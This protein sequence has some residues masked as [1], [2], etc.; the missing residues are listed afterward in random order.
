MR[1][2][3]NCST[4]ADCAR[5]R[6]QLCRDKGCLREGRQLPGSGTAPLRPVGSQR[7]D[8]TSSP[9]RHAVKTVSARAGT[10]RIRQGYDTLLDA[11]SSEQPNEIAR[12]CP[13][14]PAMAHRR[15]RRQRTATRAR[16]VENRR[17]LNP[18]HD[19]SATIH[20]DCGTLP[21]LSKEIGR[22]LGTSLH[23]HRLSLQHHRGVDA[24]PNTSAGR[25]R[26]VG[27]RVY[28]P[29]ARWRDPAASVTL[30]SSNNRLPRRSKA[31]AVS[32]SRVRVIRS[33]RRRRYWSVR[34]SLGDVAHRCRTS[35]AAAAPPTCKVA[36]ERA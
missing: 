17:R 13:F 34:R 9:A 26:L 19:C 24:R 15:A 7:V 22:D 33:F 3:R 18:P 27:G 35:R 36:R 1:D 8:A 21:R 16:G 6:A 32:M 30:Q 5:W 29:P 20:G 14:L 31:V 12:D 10:R 4:T 11:Q 2:R 23:S 25:I 28:A